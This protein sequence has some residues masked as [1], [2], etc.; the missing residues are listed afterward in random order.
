MTWLR[1]AIITPSMTLLSDEIAPHVVPNASVSKISFVHSSQRYLTHGSVI[2]KT[3]DLTLPEIN[4]IINHLPKTPRCFSSSLKPPPRDLRPIS[5][6]IS[7]SATLPFEPSE[8]IPPA[9]RCFPPPPQPDLFAAT[10]IVNGR[11]WFRSRAANLGK[12]PPP[13]LPSKADVCGSRPE[14][15]KEGGLWFFWPRG[16]EEMV[17]SCWLG[18]RSGGSAGMARGGDGDGGRRRAYA[19]AGGS[20]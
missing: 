3:V 14:G 1:S 7:P 9:R 4:T 19:G 11:V 8:D 17:G 16:S 10:C 12:S 6:A 18:K 5:S 20:A 13:P 15:R 2:V